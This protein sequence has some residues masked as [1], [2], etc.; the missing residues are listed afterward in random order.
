[1]VEGIKFGVRTAGFGFIEQK[2][3]DAPKQLDKA[4]DDGLNDLAT[5]VAREAKRIVP[6]DTRKLQNSIFVRKEGQA[7]YKIV[8]ATNYAS[9]VEYG[10]HKMVARPYLRPALYRYSSTWKKKVLDR[11]ERAS[12]GYFRSKV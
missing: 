7:K 1:M 8:A 4:M 10:T 12:K 5:L 9:H 3:K 6:V 11:F 2:L